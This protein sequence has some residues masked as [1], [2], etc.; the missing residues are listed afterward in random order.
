MALGCVIHSCRCRRCLLP[1]SQAG[2]GCMHLMHGQ[3]TEASASY[4]A[5]GKGIWNGPVWWYRYM[6][7]GVVTLCCT[8]ALQVL[9]AGGG[10]YDTFSNLPSFTNG[11]LRDS[12]ALI[13]GGTLPTSPQLMPTARESTYTAAAQGA[14]Q[15]SAGTQHSQ[16]QHSAGASCVPTESA[17][18]SFFRRSANLFSNSSSQQSAALKSGLGMTS[19]RRSFPLAVCVSVGAAGGGCMGCEPGRTTHTHHA[20]DTTWSTGDMPSL[21]LTCPSSIAVQQATPFMHR[22][23]HGNVSSPRPQPCAVRAGAAL[24]LS[25]EAMQLATAGKCCNSTTVVPG[26]GS[27]SGDCVGPWGSGSGAK[28]ATQGPSAGLGGVLLVGDSALGSAALVADGLSLSAPPSWEQ[29]TLPLGSMLSRHAL[30]VHEQVRWGRHG[31]MPA[32]RCFYPAAGCCR[33][34]HTHGPDKVLIMPLALALCLCR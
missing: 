18:E 24:P 2:Q 20:L 10:M 14:C 34:V 19:R 31:N 7:T 4:V 15:L 21:Q 27:A 28:H 6:H 22:Q 13:I 17:L 16:Q 25:V 1:R 3:C 5:C 32:V 12:L 11:N 33:H 30:G 26:S 8:M 9:V 29:C 23:A